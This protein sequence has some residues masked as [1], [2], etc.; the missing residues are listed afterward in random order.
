MRRECWINNSTINKQILKDVA[1]EG[2]LA[3]EGYVVVRFLSADQVAELKDFFYANHQKDIPG[4]Y[5]TAHS[6]GICFR[7]KM[8]NKINLITSVFTMQFIKAQKR[9]NIYNKIYKN[10]TRGGA[11]ILFE[12]VLAENGK[13]QDIYNG[14][15]NDFKINQNFLN[16]SRSILQTP[17]QI[18]DKW[19]LSPD[20]FFE[21]HSYIYSNY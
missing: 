11:F 8:N 12:K 4:F 14:I 18:L 7:Q 19:S 15:Y 2:R 10:L 9:Q 1:V 6:P 13:F 17:M 20:Y 21:N 5:A 16:K 3:T